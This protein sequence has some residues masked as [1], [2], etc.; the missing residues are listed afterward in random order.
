MAQK[1]RGAPKGSLNRLWRLAAAKPTP[2][3]LSGDRVVRLD[4]PPES[5]VSS[6]FERP[7]RSPHWL[8]KAISGSVRVA[9]RA[10]SHVEISATEMSTTA[11]MA[12]VAGSSG[13]RP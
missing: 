5:F 2:F 4:L 10:G 6:A 11:A 3:H 1:A 9:R 12:N 7:Q 13:V 8:R